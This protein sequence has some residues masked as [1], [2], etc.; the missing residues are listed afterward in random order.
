[1]LCLGANKIKKISTVRSLQ[2][3]FHQLEA[4]E[5][6]HNQIKNYQSQFSKIFEMFPKLKSLDNLDRFGNK[7]D[8]YIFS[9]IKLD[10]KVENKDYTD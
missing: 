1:M 2:K 9:E 4:F 8:P 5:C 10:R 3:I 7:I 6:Y